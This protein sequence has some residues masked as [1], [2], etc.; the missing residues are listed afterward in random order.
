MSDS[1]P[2]QFRSRRVDLEL[3]VELRFDGS[4]ARIVEGSSVNVS[5]TG[6]A[7]RLEEDVT[8][9]EGTGLRF[10][11]MRH[12]GGRGELA[13]SRPGEEG[14]ALVGLDLRRSRYDLIELLDEYGHA[15]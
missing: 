12:F 5:E 4:H 3:P 9:P 1:R 15:P 10:D 14:G 2:Q 11:V 8:H 13:W 6:M 7:V